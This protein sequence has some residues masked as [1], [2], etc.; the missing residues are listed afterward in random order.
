MKAWEMSQR[1]GRPPSLLV[2]DADHFKRYNDRQG[3]A[4]GDEVLNGLAR[5][6]SA[7][8]HRPDGLVARVGGE[9]FAIL[10][11]DTD[12]EGAMRIAGKVH[13]AVATLAVP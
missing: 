13:E 9:G 2:V 8:V 12:R 10:L 11:P 5:C 6:L 7:G 3:H 1:T 4:V